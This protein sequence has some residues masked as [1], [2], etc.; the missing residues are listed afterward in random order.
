MNWKIMFFS[1]SLFTRMW[2]TQERE[3]L[4]FFLF[5]ALEIFFLAFL[6]FIKTLRHSTFVEQWSIISLKH[7]LKVVMLINQRRRRRHALETKALL[8][9]QNERQLAIGKPVAREMVT[10]HRC[11]YGSSGALACSPLEWVMPWMKGF[12]IFNFFW[13]PW[14]E[15]I[16][17]FFFF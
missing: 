9:L 5:K 1:T 15:R 12:Q 11:S 10:R 16:V 7:T 13:V 4:R 14:K 8:E 3:V 2:A 6:K 17:V